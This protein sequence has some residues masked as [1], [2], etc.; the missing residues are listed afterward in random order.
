MN[1]HAKNSTYPIAAAYLS[2]QPQICRGPTWNGNRKPRDATLSHA[3]ASRSGTWRDRAPSASRRLCVE[4]TTEGQPPVYYPA[5]MSVIAG[6]SFPPTCRLGCSTRRQSAP[7]LAA[8]GLITGEIP[9]ITRGAQA[10]REGLCSSLGHLVNCHLESPKYPR[11]PT[12][13]TILRFMRHQMI[14]RR[15]RWMYP[16]LILT[17]RTR[18]GSQNRWGHYWRRKALLWRSDT[19]HR[20]D[21]TPRR[22]LISGA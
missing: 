13:G 17:Y 12:L 3:A 5:S 19:V 11:G 16:P 8:A 15:R 9:P 1:S 2:R 4:V 10:I 7:T 18:Q 20:G 14:D 6:F 22:F 21:A